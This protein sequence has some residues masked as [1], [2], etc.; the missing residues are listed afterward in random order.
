MCTHVC[1]CG[2]LANNTNDQARTSQVRLLTPSAGVGEWVWS[3]KEGFSTPTTHNA[4]NIAPTSY[5]VQPTYPSASDLKVFESQNNAAWLPSNETV[6]NFSGTGF[7]DMDGIPIGMAIDLDTQSALLSSGFPLTPS[8]ESQD[9]LPTPG[10]V[11]SP[12]EVQ[13]HDLQRPSLPHTTS[14]VSSSVPATPTSVAMLELEA[15]VQY[16]Q[17]KQGEYLETGGAALGLEQY[18]QSLSSAFAFTT[19]PPAPVPAP[20]SLQATQVVLETST[21]Q[22]SNQPSMSPLPKPAYV[23]LP[24]PGWLDPE[25]LPVE[26]SIQ[27]AMVDLSQQA[28]GD[29]LSVVGASTWLPPTAP[30]AGSRYEPYRNSSIASTSSS[31][32]QSF[33]T[34]PAFPAHRAAGVEASG[35]RRRSLT[36]E[37][38]SGVPSGLVDRVRAMDVSLQQQSLPSSPRVNSKKFSSMPSRR[39]RA[40]AAAGVQEARGEMGSIKERRMASLA[41]R[42][43]VAVAQRGALAGVF[44]RSEPVI[45][46]EAVLSPTISEFSLAL[47][48]PTS[49][50]FSPPC[51]PARAA[52]GADGEVIGE[53]KAKIAL[54]HHRTKLQRNVLNQVVTSLQ[55]AYKHCRR[56]GEL[57]Q[58]E[59]ESLNMDGVW[60]TA[61][62]TWSTS[63]AVVAG[64]TKETRKNR[65]KAESKMRMR[66]KEIAQFTALVSF[67]KVALNHLANPGKEDRLGRAVVQVMK[68]HEEEWDV[69]RA[70]EKR[71]WNTVRGK[72]GLNEM[73]LRRLMDRIGC[74]G[75]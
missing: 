24:A 37:S 17:P 34:S 42:S 48:T 18:P 61:D 11:Y 64:E 51:T 1:G 65:Q 29:W 50:T 22:M 13:T 75:V 6:N 41:S 23:P 71:L 4:I 19:F 47:S 31:S 45:V 33:S 5:T 36:V 56:Q 44:A 66:R 35:S 62:P 54:H 8:V 21:P 60:D 52:F 72:L 53:G 40:P 55:G 59:L 68:E 9:A 70:L 49:L 38:F 26:I 25:V 30:V 16:Q 2:G 20:E 46:N 67:A 10:L 3:T 63:G 12:T 32:S 14:S 73:V 58:L 69:L 57:L 27:T 28:V 15:P 74:V 43:G 39:V 7:V